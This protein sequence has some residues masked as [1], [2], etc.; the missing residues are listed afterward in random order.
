MTTIPGSVVCQRV[1]F[2]YRHG[3][4]G[5]VAEIRLLHILDNNSCSYVFS[6]LLNIKEE[7]NPEV[8]KKLRDLGKTMADDL[9][10]HQKVYSGNEPL[11]EVLTTVVNQI[12]GILIDEPSIWLP[13]YHDKE[14]IKQAISEKGKI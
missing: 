14:K 10:L 2:V 8:K 3:S 7:L 11:N 5:N 1:D 12:E 9:K 6:E 13:D 4:I